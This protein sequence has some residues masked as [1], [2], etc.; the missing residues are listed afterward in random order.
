MKTSKPAVIALILWLLFVAS[1]AFAVF[2]SPYPPKTYPPDQIT[3]IADGHGNFGDDNQG[4]GIAKK[5]K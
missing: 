4:V 3:I 1:N 5:P 2:K